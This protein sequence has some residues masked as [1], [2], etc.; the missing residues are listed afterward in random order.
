MKDNKCEFKSDWSNYVE[1]YIQTF[2]KLLVSDM[3]MKRGK[4]KVKIRTHGVDSAMNL[5]YFKENDLSC[6]PMTLN[7]NKGVKY[8]LVIDIIQV[9]FT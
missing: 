4:C 6:N 5:N 1:G 3:V 2:D 9:F 7:S 8:T